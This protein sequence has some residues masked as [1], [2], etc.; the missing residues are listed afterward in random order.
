[1]ILKSTYRLIQP[2]QYNVNRMF[3]NHYITYITYIKYWPNFIH[4]WDKDTLF[5]EKD[6]HWTSLKYLTDLWLYIY[7][8]QI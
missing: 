3:E 2:T 6:A 1:M 8:D 7:L 4:I 5:S